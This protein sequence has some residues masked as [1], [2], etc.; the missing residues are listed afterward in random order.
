M[1]NVLVNAFANMDKE[2]FAT[3]LTEFSY[4]YMDVFDEDVQ[5]A[6]INARNS[7]ESAKQIIEEVRRNNDIPEFY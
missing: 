7:L 2:G 4:A 1:S 5:K 3:W 6:L